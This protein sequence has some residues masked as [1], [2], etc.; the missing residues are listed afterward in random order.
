M[1]R[2]STRSPGMATLPKL[3]FL[4]TPEF[5][6]LILMIRTGIGFDIHRFAADEL[7]CQAFSLPG[8]GYG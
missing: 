4:L 8:G 5:W 1:G 3:D 2:D 7:Q 6:I